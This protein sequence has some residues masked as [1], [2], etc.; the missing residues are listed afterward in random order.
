MMKVVVRFTAKQE[1][2]ALPVLLRFSPGMILPNRTY[3]LP[4]EAVL[5]LV[6]EGVSFTEISRE[7]AS[8][9]S[10]GASIGER[11]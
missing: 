9:S 5:R 3:I 11:V 7:A 8:I 10:E 1:A 2:K 6:H 4:E